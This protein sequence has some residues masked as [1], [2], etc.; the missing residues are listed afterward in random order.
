M[1]A[2][3][4]LLEAKRLKRGLGRR[5]RVLDGES[6]SGN[7]YEK[8]RLEDLRLAW[9]DEHRD[10]LAGACREVLTR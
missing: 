10:A 4:L 1:E 9:L 5:S 6:L 2:L 7:D 8:I 3:P